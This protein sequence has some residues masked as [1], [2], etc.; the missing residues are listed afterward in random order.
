MY[1]YHSIHV[2]SSADGHLGCFH[3][4]A[5]VN[6]MHTILEHFLI[7]VNVQITSLYSTMTFSKFIFHKGATVQKIKQYPYAVLLPSKAMCG[8]EELQ[9]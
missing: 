8:T 1:M 4:L 3:V 2:H 6:S 7:I 5:I 9:F